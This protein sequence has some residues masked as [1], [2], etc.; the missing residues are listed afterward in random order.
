MDEFETEE[1]YEARGEMI[2][3]LF[4]IFRHNSIAVPDGIQFKLY[5]YSL[6]QVPNKVTMK[7]LFKKKP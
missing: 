1:H 6:V 5:L 4:K 7:S 3:L 2:S